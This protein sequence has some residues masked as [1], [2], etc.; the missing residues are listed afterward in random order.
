MAQHYIALTF[1]LID[2]GRLAQQFEQALEEAQVAIIG[3][4]EQYG[5]KAQKAK[6]K[7]R[8]DIEMVCLDAGD[9]MFAIVGQVQTAVP[10]PPASATL[11]LADQDVDT[12]LPLLLVRKSGSTHDSP[13][14]AVLTTTDGRAVDTETGAPEK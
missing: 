2:E 5:E 6:A 9:R 4:L 14:Q 13:R 12:G 11:A 8:L 10:K 7:V 1:P 3:H